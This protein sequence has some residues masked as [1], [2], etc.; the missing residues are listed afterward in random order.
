MHNEIAAL[1]AA[2]VSAETWDS[3]KHGKCQIMWYHFG[4]IPDGF[5]NLPSP[6]VVEHG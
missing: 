5:F 1:E 4:H 3:A 6:M 2:A